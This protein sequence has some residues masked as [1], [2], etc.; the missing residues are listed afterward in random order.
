MYIKDF[1]LEKWLNPIVEDAKYNLGSSCVKA[2]TVEELFEFIGK[3][4]NEFTKELQKMSLHYGHFFGFERLLIAISK[5]YKDVTK[6]MILTVHGGTGANNL[7]ITELVEPM[8]NVIALVPNYQQHY[9]I[10][11][12]LG[13]EVRYLELKEGNGYLPDLNELRSLV[14]QNTKMITLSNPNNPTGA[15]IEA[16]MLKEICKIAESVDAYVLC[17]EIYRGLNEGY[18]TSIIELYQKGIVT[19]STSKVFSMAGTRV[20]WIVTRDKETYDRLENRRSYDTI[21]NGVFD[22]LITAIAFEHFEKILERNREIVSESKV[23]VDKWLETQPYLS[24]NYEQ[25][26]TTI[27]VKYDFDIPSDVLCKDI[28]EKASVALCHGD[29]FEIPHSFRIGYAF[30]DPKTLET[31]LEV[32]GEYFANLK[33]EKNV[34]TV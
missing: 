10:P 34:T 19:S 8:D 33:I 20:G 16:E 26:G 12:S 5:M 32:L 22:E 30:G 24:A 31:G 18:M 14:D 11:E 4:V 29:C 15:F 17:D 28:L 21:C 1:K 3:D 13:A 7:V 6:D 27:F 23:I 2:F 25:C 9:S